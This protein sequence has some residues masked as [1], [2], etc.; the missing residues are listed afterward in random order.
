MAPP[1]PPPPTILKPVD[2]IQ[3]LVDKYVPE[4]AIGL[5][6]ATLLYRAVQRVVEHVAPA[7]P[8]P[9]A[10]AWSHPSQPPPPLDPAA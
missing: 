1:P 6:K 2:A 4:Q 5:L 9:P 10:A 8:A 7:P 3:M